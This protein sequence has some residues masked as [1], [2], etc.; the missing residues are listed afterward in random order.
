MVYLS[1]RAIV[2]HAGRF[3]SD[4]NEEQTFAM[5]GVLFL[6]FYFYVHLDNKIYIV[7]IWIINQTAVVGGRFEEVPGCSYLRFTPFAAWAI[8]LLPFRKFLFSRRRVTFP[9]TAWCAFFS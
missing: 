7:V 3:D 2:W 5:R 9:Q 4:R 8:Q 1:R 6:S